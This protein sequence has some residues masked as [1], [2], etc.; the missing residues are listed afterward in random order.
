MTTT[1]DRPARLAPK[2]PAEERD[3][4]V[5]YHRAEGERCWAAYE[6]LAR[7]GQTE[8]AEVFRRRSVE[9]D[10]AA[11]DVLRSYRKPVATAEQRAALGLCGGCRW[12]CQ[13]AANLGTCAVLNA[14]A[15]G[16]AR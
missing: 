4:A 6:A 1:M 12:T 5:R 2:T 9:A 15:A 7:A 14:I 13:G 16:V 11:D 8:E 10:L 3:S